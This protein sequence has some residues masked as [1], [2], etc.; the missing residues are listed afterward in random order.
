MVSEGVDIPRLRVGVYAT[1]TTTELFF[2]QAVGRFVRWTRGVPRQKAYVFIPDDP[3]L[4]TLAADRRAA[5]PLAAA[6]RRRS[7]L[8]PGL[9]ES[10]TQQPD[11]EQ[12]SLFSVISAV[13]SGAAEPADDE[14]W[15]VLDAHDERP[16]DEIKI[17]LAPPPPLRADSTGTAEQGLTR[18]EAKQRLRDANA[19]VARE[20]SRRTGLTHAQVN[21][22]LNHHAGVQRLARRRSTSSN[23]LRMADRWIATAR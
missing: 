12:L 21:G 17:L 9:D 23:A 6:P 16:G 5:P 1:T 13:A 4:R 14:I 7:R 18:R 22:E 10:R 11:D 20:L 3:R 15:R 19:D 2:R 8:D